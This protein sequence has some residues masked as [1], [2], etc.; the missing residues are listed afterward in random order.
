M[1]ESILKKLK[2]LTLNTHNTKFFAAKAEQI[3]LK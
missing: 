3:L 1:K 2:Q